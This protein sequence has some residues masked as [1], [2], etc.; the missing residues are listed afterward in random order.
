MASDLAK[1]RRRGERGKVGRGGEGVGCGQEVSLGVVMP[2][3]NEAGTVEE[4]LRRILAQRCVCEVVVVDDASR[5]GTGERLAD[6]V[7]LDPR[8]RVFRH[9]VNRGKGAAIRTGL[10]WMTASVVVI[11]DADLEYDPADYPAL[12]QPI[13]AGGAEA[14]YG[15]RL[16]LPGNVFLG[17]WHL[18]S[19]RMLTKLANWM[20]GL[21]LTDEATGLKMM[22]RELLCRLNLREDGFG[23]CPEV[24]AKLAKAGVRIREVPIRYAARS[25]SEGKKLRLRHS[26]EA[27]VCLLRYAGMPGRGGGNPGGGCVR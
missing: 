22:R 21:Q 15:T 19:N 3:F 4:V 7:R 10:R 23:F 18:F 11:Q 5:D 13:R 20:T 27:L 1:R 14:V 6:L 16:R 25:R 24:T 12:L 17:R 8:V 26:V 2:V 9:E